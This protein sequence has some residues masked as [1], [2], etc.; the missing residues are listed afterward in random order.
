MG[1]VVTVTSTFDIVGPSQD[2]DI[3]LFLHPRQVPPSIYHVLVALRCGPIISA[4]MA[5]VF[6]DI[7]MFIQI[8][9]S[10]L[11]MRIIGFYICSHYHFV[12]S[13]VDTVLF[14]CGFCY[15]DGSVDVF[16]LS[17]DIFVSMSVQ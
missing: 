13:R 2:E 11:I 3:P 17:M 10:F 7:D 6:L 12:M 15:F 1:K 14:I 5:A 4:S 16:F 9:L 8:R